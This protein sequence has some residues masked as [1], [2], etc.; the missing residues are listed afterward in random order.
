MILTFLSIAIFPDFYMYHTLI[1]NGIY[2][3]WLA[4]G[5]PII[6]NPV[7]WIPAIPTFFIMPWL[8]FPYLSP[9]YFLPLLLL[10]RAAMKNAKQRIIIEHDKLS[11]VHEPRSA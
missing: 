4:S 2:L 6:K 1:F 10:D 9:F 5:N 11:L 8:M 7:K 3:L